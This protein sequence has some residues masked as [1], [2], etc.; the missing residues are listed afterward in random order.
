MNLGMNRISSIP[1]RAFAGCSSLQRID[2]DYNQI[3]SIEERAFSS[4]GNLTLVALTYN[5]ITD[6]GIHPNAFANLGNSATILGLGRNNITQL[7]EG[8]FKRVLNT[9]KEVIAGT[10]YCN[11]S[12]CYYDYLSCDEGADWICKGKEMYHEKLVGFRCTGDEF[13]DIWEYCE[14][15][16]SIYF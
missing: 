7:R 1:K 8:T 4:T 5:S 11:P 14:S 3:G 13:E 9:V 6:D 10:G 15:R 16:Q 2:L 12:A